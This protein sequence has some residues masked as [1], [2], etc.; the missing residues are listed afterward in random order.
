MDNRR[1]TG[2]QEP[3]SPADPDPVSGPTARPE[4]SLPMPPAAPS[5][6]EGERRRGELSP[7]ELE[8]LRL[9][10]AGQT[11]QQIATALEPVMDYRRAEG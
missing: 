3:A 9:L 5:E 11:D 7:R 8:V 2:A 10:A 6:P 1:G 4:P